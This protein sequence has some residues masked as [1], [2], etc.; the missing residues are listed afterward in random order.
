M[1]YNTAAAF[2]LRDF[3]SELSD[4]CII[5]NARSRVE[6]GVVGGG[7]YVRRDWFARPL[8][9]SISSLQGLQVQVCHG[10]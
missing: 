1:L 9:C 5:A 4:F 2:Y 8:V 3:V 6:V 7:A 10:R